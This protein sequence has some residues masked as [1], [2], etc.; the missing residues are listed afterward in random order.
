MKALVG[1][2]N[3]EKALVGAFSVIVKSSETFGEPSFQALVIT[4]C[5]ARILAALVW[6]PGGGACG[7]DT[8]SRY[9]STSPRPHGYRSPAVVTICSIPPPITGQAPGEGVWWRSLNTYLLSTLSTIYV[10][11]PAQCQ[12]L[13]LCTAFYADNILA[14]LNFFLECFDDLIPPEI[15]LELRIE[16]S[17]R[18]Q[19]Q[20]SIS[21]AVCVGG[22]GI[23][24]EM[25]WDGQ[26]RIFNILV[27]VNTH[28]IKT[29][30]KRPGGSSSSTNITSHNTNYA[31]A[32]TSCKKVEKTLQ[33]AVSAMTSF[34]LI[35]TPVSCPRPGS[36]SSV[37]VGTEIK[38]N[39]KNCSS[40]IHQS[41]LILTSVY[42]DIYNIYRMCLVESARLTSR[43]KCENSWDT[44]ITHV[45]RSATENFSLIIWVTQVSQLFSHFWRLV[46]CVKIS[47]A[48]TLYNL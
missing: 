39:R 33:R 24:C 44:W 26:G 18:A 9:T 40:N 10:Y 12:P 34:P 32:S 31:G 11:T 22:G 41:F 35:V 2:F 4:F 17:S 25:L 43:Q 1:A 37:W 47:A 42:I 19:Q 46:G 5:W 27:S 45:I 7:A 28:W 23:L 8:Y 29:D 36:L 3:Q 16:I 15:V 30:N 14:L 21:M 38:G 6:G 13:L 48:C 20:V